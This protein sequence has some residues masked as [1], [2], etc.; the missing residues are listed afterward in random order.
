MTNRILTALI[1]RIAGIFLFIKI[2][3]YFGSYFMSV[4]S[5]ATLA[6]M[7]S[8][9]DE[10]VNKFFIKGS[11]LILANILVSLFLF[12]KAEWISKHL[13]KTDN[14]VVLEL[15]PNSIAKAILMTV[16]IV[17]LATS[18]YSLPEFIGYLIKLI[19][20]Q[21]GTDT[22]ALNIRD[23][24]AAKFILRTTIALL[25]I[26]KIQRISDWISRKL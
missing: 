3:D 10:V 23:I 5:T 19:Q 18:L 1:I 20:K 16:G 11:F 15:N 25:L 7:D 8:E 22:H 12:L 24:L 13:I 2:F 14:E 17:W 26:F 4:Y 9:G 6:I 21:N